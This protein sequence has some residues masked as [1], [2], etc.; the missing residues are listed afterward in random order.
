MQI[1]N[2]KT[3]FYFLKSTYVQVWS[4]QKLNKFNLNVIEI[5]K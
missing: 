1:K 4:V 5:K 2:C 3:E